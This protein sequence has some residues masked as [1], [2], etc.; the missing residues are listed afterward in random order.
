MIHDFYDRNNELIPQKESI[1]QVIEALIA[2]FKA[3]GKLLLCG[4]GGSAADC[5][6]IAGELLKGFLKRRAVT[7]TD[8]KLLEKAACELQM[9]DS[10][11]R[12]GNNLQRGLPVISLVNMISVSSAFA[13]DVD[14]N[15]TFAQLVYVLGNPGDAVLLISTSGNSESILQAAVTA[16]AK[17]VLTIGLTGRTGGMLAEITDHSIHTPSDETYRIQEYHLPVYHYICAKLEQE[18]FDDDGK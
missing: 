7:E 9:P 4:N 6:H 17:N 14:P 10:G 11:N 15:L 12:L 8:K 5:E 18:F 16:K 13:N 3:G 1:E 2:V